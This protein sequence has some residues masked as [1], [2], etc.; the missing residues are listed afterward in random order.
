MAGGDAGALVRARSTPYASAIATRSPVNVIAPMIAAALGNGNATLGVTDTVDNQ[1]GCIPGLR[2][3]RARRA[4]KPARLA[5]R[6]AYPDTDT[7]AGWLQGAHEPQQTPVGWLG[8]R[9]SC[10]ADGCR[11]SSVMQPIEAF[12]SSAKIS[13]LSP[14]C[15]SCCLQ[16]DVCAI[17]GLRYALTPV[18]GASRCVCN[19]T[20]VGPC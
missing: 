19:A 12:T 16:L 3:H 17:S 8:K 11:L 5:S 18:Q 9:A 10:A 1:Y 6:P 2:S 7:A 14:A 20:E 13:M 15:T 4:G